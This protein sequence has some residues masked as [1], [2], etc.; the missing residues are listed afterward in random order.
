MTDKIVTVSPSILRDPPRHPRYIAVPR[1]ESL[2]VKEIGVFSIIVRTQDYH[3]AIVLFLGG[4]PT[5]YDAVK[6]LQQNPAL[7]HAEDYVVI[8]CEMLD[9]YP[10]AHRH[11][12]AIGESGYMYPPGNRLFFAN[13]EAKK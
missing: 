11:A 1:D 7:I 13:C 10:E 12:M 6:F 5:A 9:T 3:G 8:G 4:S 2:P